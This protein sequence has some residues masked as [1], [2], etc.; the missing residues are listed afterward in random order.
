VIWLVNDG[1]KTMNR[2]LLPVLALAGLAGCATD[3][4]M[5]DKQEPEAVDTAVKRARFEMGCPEATGHTLSRVI[6]QPAINAPRYGGVTRA[7]Y[8]IGIEGCGKRST[9]VVV[10]ALEGS[11]C[12]AAEGRR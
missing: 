11:G 3:Q 5:L 12:F 2:S 4:Q 9:S 8:T 1:D 6:V 10:C 7:E